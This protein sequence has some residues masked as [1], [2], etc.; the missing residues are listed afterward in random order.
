MS[1]AA[2]TTFGFITGS[3]VSKAVTLGYG[4]GSAPPTPPATGGD[5]FIPYNQAD[6]RRYRAK[7]KRD[8]EQV[9]ETYRE[10]LE[11]A[12]G[13]RLEIDR[14]MHPPAA[15]FDKKSAKAA[16]KPAEPL[17]N[18]AKLTEKQTRRITELNR[19]IGMLMAEAHILEVQAQEAAM[20]ARR[21][22]DEEDMHIITNLLNA[23]V[24]ETKH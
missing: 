16:A 14:I 8:R 23:H 6:V 4:A 3:T 22:Q 21:A 12:N 17:P 11:A 10:K 2:I 20:A 15:D 18:L 24:F 1:I 5:N 19:Q 9:E 7:L 13:I